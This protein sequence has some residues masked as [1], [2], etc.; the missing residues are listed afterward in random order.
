MRFKAVSDKGNIRKSNEDN[1]YIDQDKAFFMVADGMGGHAAGEVASQIAADVSSDYD[2]NLE[3][4]VE[5]MENLINQANQEIISESREKSHQRGMGT[6]FSSVII[7]KQVLYYANLGD[8]RIY[9]F[10]SSEEKLQ[11]ISK[12]HSLVG[13]LLRDGKIT[14]EEAFKHPKKNI[15]TQALGLDR[16][17]DIDSGLYNLGSDDLILLCTDGLSDLI[18][19]EDMQNIIINNDNIEKMADE[20]LEK[21]L[22]NGGT[23]NITFI[24][25]E[26]NNN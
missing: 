18:R 9:V 11:K 23:D 25:I 19:K 21:A 8:S 6:T 5:T 2:F 15:V 22:A 10:D 20:L 26:Q 13:Q 7:E 12:D 14:E 3:S 16:E 1:Y 4:P 24:I 17:I